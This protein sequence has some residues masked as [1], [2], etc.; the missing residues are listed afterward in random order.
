MLVPAG[1]ALADAVVRVSGP[2]KGPVTANCEGLA[3][4]DL[5]RLPDGAVLLVLPGVC[6]RPRWVEVTGPV[7]FME[8]E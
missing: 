4:R 7:P 2:W 3:V 6:K 5:V 1:A 8:A